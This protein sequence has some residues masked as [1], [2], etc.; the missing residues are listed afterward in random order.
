MEMKTKKIMVIENKT[1]DSWRAEYECEDG[2]VSLS[3]H[4]FEPLTKYISY[5]EFK[6]DYTIEGV[7]D[8]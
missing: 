4:G 8:E 5:S 3:R 7:L 1:G 2:L 6:S